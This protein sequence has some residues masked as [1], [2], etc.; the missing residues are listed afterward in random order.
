MVL[1]APS[2]APSPAEPQS[3]LLLAS[4][5]ISLRMRTSK[6]VPFLSRSS[7]LIVMI[8][9]EPSIVT[10]VSSVIPPR[11][12]RLTM[13]LIALSGSTGSE[14][15][16]MILVFLLTPVSPS[17]GATVAT[18]GGVTS[19]ELSI[20]VNPKLVNVCRGKPARLRI[21]VFKFTV[22]LS[23][24]LSKLM[25][26]MITVCESA[27]TLS[28]MGTVLE[29]KFLTKEIFDAVMVLGSI[30]SSKSTVTFGHRSILFAVSAGT[31][32]VTMGPVLSTVVPCCKTKICRCCSSAGKVLK[33][34]GN[35]YLIGRCR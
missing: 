18:V 27:D 8:V 20:V 5:T 22:K 1:G 6:V 33:L 4:S 23:K 31:D 3:R 12:D 16:I 2:Q 19:A 11:R 28:D 24:L 9:R 35:V 15:V 32:P 30:S 10:C 14:R 29:S 7:G 17:N 13:P 21:P 26:L 34:V 25:G